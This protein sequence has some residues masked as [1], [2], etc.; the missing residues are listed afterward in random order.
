MATWTGTFQ[1]RKDTE[2][3]T[4]VGR[5]TLQWVEGEDVLF[6]VSEDYDGSETPQQ[7]KTRLEGL[8]D[9]ELARQSESDTV[10][11]QLLNLMNG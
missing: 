2:A 3:G 5:V 11:T 8:R 9:A 4:K 7:F 1:K 6:D 10:T